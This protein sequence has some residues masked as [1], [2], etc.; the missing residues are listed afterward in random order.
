MDKKHTLENINVDFIVPTDL[1]EE[2]NRKRHYMEITIASLRSCLQLHQM[3]MNMGRYEPDKIIA[4]HKALFEALEIRQ[5][6]ESY[7]AI[8]N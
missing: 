6:L 2:F 3:Q 8:L 1:F 7:I 4:C 5:K